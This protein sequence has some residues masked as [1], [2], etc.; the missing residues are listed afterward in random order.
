MARQDEPY[1][2]HWADRAAAKTVA[3]HPDATTYVLAAGITPSGQIHIG[4]FREIIT[5]DLVVRAMRDLGKQVRFIY[6]WDDFDVFRKVPQNMP[7]QAMLTENLRR[8]IADVPDPYGENESYA[9]RN[10]DELE[11]GI[12]P[13]GIHCEFIRQHV[14]YRR[15]DYAAGI[16]TALEQKDVIRSILDEYRT[17][18]LPEDWLP[19]AG[20]CDRC[21]RDRINFCWEGGDMVSYSCATEGCGHQQRVDLREG[22]NVKL[23]WR[24][25]W[26]MRWAKERVHFEPGGKDHSSEGSSYDTG[27]RIVDQVYGY[28][29]PVYVA[30]DFVIGKSGGKLSSSRGA[31][32]V[33]TTLEIYEPHLLRWLFAS[34]RP[35]TEFVIHFDEDVLKVYEDYDKARRLAYQPQDGGKKDKKRQIARRAMDLARVGGDPIQPT[36]SLPFQPSFRKLTEI[37]QIYDGDLPLTLGYFVESGKIITEEERRLF[38]VRARCAWNW[39]DFHAPK[40]FCYRIRKEQAARTLP[41]AEWAVLKKLVGFLAEKPGASESELVP[42]MRTLLEGSELDAQTF[43]PVVYDLLLDR[44]KGPKLTT[45]FTTIEHSHLIRLLSAG[46]SNPPS[47]SSTS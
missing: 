40:S 42:H 46:L 33:G 3:A 5:V 7:Q 9:A 36:D 47:S 17:T 44:P 6:S 28:Q 14:C 8:S 39:I 21:G 34:Y 24:V 1:Y 2:S 18:P 15:G 35:N 22:G 19:L 4:N 45:L 30:Y 37:L 13:L 23:P 41:T 12:A 20:F 32:T 25:D 29:A 10:I 31:T 27:K 11:R 16:R 38:G 43:F 26:P